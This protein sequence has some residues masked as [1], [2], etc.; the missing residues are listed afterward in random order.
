MKTKY[1]VYTLIICY[2]IKI[3]MAILQDYIVE[4]LI[5]DLNIEPLE[6]GL[7]AG[8]PNLLILISII[9]LIVKI[10]RY[11]NRKDFLNS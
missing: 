4:Y 6:L 10:F 9:G 7:I 1:F 8:I 11:H 5:L 2:A 3:G